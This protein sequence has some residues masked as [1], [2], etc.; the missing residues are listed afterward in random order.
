[1]SETTYR[2]SGHVVRYELA[3]ERAAF[4]TVRE[5]GI[6]EERNGVFTVRAAPWGELASPQLHADAL[7]ALVA[8]V[9]ARVAAPLRIE[10]LVATHGAARHAFADER[11]SREWSDE[12]ARLHISIV[13][14]TLPLRVLLDLGST[15]A[16][17][18]DLADLEVAAH[19]LAIARPHSLEQNADVVLE[20][21]VAA[22]LL[23]LLAREQQR[24][25]PQLIEQRECAEMPLDG[26]GVPVRDSAITAGALLPNVFR[27]SYRHRPIRLPFH[28]AMR[29]HGVMRPAPFEAVALTAPP[30]M[31]GT[32]L[33]LHALLL[34]TDESTAV[35][36]V[37]SFD[38]RSIVAAAA[39][40]R[41][42]PIEGGA[43]GSALLVQDASLALP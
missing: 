35:H 2:K 37:C 10:R 21:S 27:P 32:T 9:H 30:R 20:P 40:L 36:A 29:E 15:T 1:V 28:L 38:V 12:A 42:Y 8:S 23:L 18:I 22:P 26:E 7:H 17:A 31:E 25:I 6:A 16:D 13:S 34:A 5:S 19:A 33:R 24:S 39:P 4:V 3:H 41:W 43:L 14:A 11:G